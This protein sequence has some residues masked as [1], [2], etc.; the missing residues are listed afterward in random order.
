MSKKGSKKNNSNRRR[1][2]S[3]SK[4]L[5]KTLL[6]GDDGDNVNVDRQNTRRA[7]GKI[8]I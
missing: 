8:S 1:S 3:I 2:K 7:D 6:G 4:S 5:L